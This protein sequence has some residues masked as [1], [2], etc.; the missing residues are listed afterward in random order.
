MT[1]VSRIYSIVSE[2]PTEPTTGDTIRVL[3]VSDLH[4]NPE[5]IDLT[6]AL[7]KQF[8]TNFVIDTGD[9]NDWGTKFEDLI[10]KGIGTVGLKYLYVKGNHDSSA[11]VQEV[12]KQPN[13]IVLD[14]KV[15]KVEGLTIAGISDPRFT[16]DKADGDDNAS[17]A[18][19]TSVGKKLAKTIDA[20]GALVDITVFHDPK[21][22]TPLYGV[23]PLILVGHSHARKVSVVGDGQTLLMVGGSTGG[24]GLRGTEAANVTPL[25]ASIIYISKSTKRVIAWDEITQG[26]LGQTD[27]SIKRKENPISATS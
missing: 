7:A 21:S 12:A 14:D 13:V 23:A 16:P 8:K 2:L 25:E 26:G 10:V 17:L 11:T 5:S 9:L 1:N 18:K 19:I 22:S 3:H 20:A 4:N 24:A 15:V 6:K 27:I